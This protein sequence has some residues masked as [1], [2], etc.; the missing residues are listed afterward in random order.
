MLDGRLDITPEQLRAFCER[1]AITRLAVF[2]SVLREDFSQK[3]DVDVLVEFDP[4]HQVGLNFF[5]IREELAELV[6]RP[7]DLVTPG[8]I[9]D[10]YRTSIL[11]AAKDL[12][13]AA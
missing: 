8:S 6:G 4:G 9:R 5:S 7:V 10:A 1:H 13:V 12:Y 3:S 11:D 2:G